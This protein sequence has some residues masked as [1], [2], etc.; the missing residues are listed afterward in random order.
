MRSV[1]LHSTSGRDME[2][3]KE[4]TGITNH[5]LKE[6]KKEGTGVTNHILKTVV[7]RLYLKVISYYHWE[8]F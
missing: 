3:K 7:N 4:R 8:D 2:G 1:G 6:R 5:I